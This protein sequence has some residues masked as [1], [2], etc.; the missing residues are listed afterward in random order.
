MSFLWRLF[1]AEKPPDDYESVLAALANDIAKRQT[2]LSE[3]RAR[4]RRATTLVTLY[5]LAAYL[6]YLAVW[7]FGF[8][9]AGRSRS[10]SGRGVE[11]AVRA[12]PVFVGPILILFIRRIVQVWYNRKG[13]AEEKTLQALLKQQRA[14]VEEIKKKTNFYSTRDLLSRYDASAPGSPASASPSVRG[15]QPQTQTPQRGSGSSASAAPQRARPSVGGQQL[16]QQIQPQRQAQQP[17]QNQQPLP[18]QR[19]WFDALA[20]LLVGAEDPSVLSEKQKYALICE[21]CF[22]HNGLVPEGVWEGM[23]YTCPKCGHFNPS[24]R[25]KRLGLVSPTTPSSMSA[26]QAGRGGLPPHFQALEMQRGAQAAAQGGGSAMSPSAG[27]QAGAEDGLR[28]RSAR[29]ER[30]GGGVQDKDDDGDE[31]GD[32][33]D[34]EERMEVDSS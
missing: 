27:L 20:D 16:Q 9:A 3:I 23:Q 4:E 29:K 22:A 10:A 34:G 1:R 2:L 15:G 13:N 21:R 24:A 6:L 31:D 17:Q 26:S 30:T 33:G 5:T 32:G 28:R 14:K 12:L 7:Y 8:V 25:S 19:K 18:A 11:R